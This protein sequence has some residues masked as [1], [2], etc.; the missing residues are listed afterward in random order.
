MKWHKLTG[1][2]YCGDKGTSSYGGPV[3]YYIE[4]GQNSHLWSVRRHE[5]WEDYTD[6][7]VTFF[8]EEF[9]TLREAKE[10]AE[11]GGNRNA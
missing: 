1:P 8:R 10:Y 4:K 2:G 9:K 3:R 5:M 6:G 11:K 7:R